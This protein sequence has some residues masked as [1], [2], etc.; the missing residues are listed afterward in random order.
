MHVNELTKR[1]KREEKKDEEWIEGR[2]GGKRYYGGAG[3]RVTNRV[4]CTLQRDLSPRGDSM[5]CYPE[6]TV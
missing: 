1:G 5:I 6:G 2:R 3:E 4:V